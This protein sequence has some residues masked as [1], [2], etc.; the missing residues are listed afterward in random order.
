MPCSS[1]VWRYRV[2]SKQLCLLPARHSDGAKPSRQDSV[3]KQLGQRFDVIWT[4]HEPGRWLLH[5]H[6]PHHTVNNN[7]AEQGAGGLTMIIDVSR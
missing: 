3:R 7:V 4:T 1:D 5:C 2:V 6:I